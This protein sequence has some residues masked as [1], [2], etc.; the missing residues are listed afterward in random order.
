M[1]GREAGQTR[2]RGT[3]MYLRGQRHTLGMIEEIGNVADAGAWRLP[4]PLS[5]SHLSWLAGTRPVSQKIDSV[6]AQF[7]MIDGINGP[8]LVQDV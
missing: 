1:A 5:S 8:H 6:L 2:E 7:D 3:R 4:L